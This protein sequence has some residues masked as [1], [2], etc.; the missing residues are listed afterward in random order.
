MKKGV[1]CFVLGFLSMV[2]FSNEIAMNKT[3]LQVINQIN[4]TLPLLEKARKEQGSGA[5]S[6]IHFN[7]FKNADGKIVNGV[8]EDFLEIRKA[9]IGHINKQPI[10]PKKVASLAFD[11]IEGD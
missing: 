8:R 9:L 3:L 1:V 5:R 10:A 2:V 11:F 4:A 7:K 6:M